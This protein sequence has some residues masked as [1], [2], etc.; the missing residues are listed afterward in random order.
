MTAARLVVAQNMAAQHGAR[1]KD[2]GASPPRLSEDLLLSALNLLALQL[3]HLEVG[4]VGL[5]GG[6]SLIP[7][8]LP[9]H[10]LSEAVNL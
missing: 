7:P 3:N 10:A 4:W 5:V 6:G 8:S 9:P 1:G 2:Q